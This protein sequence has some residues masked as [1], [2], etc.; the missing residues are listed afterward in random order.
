MSARPPPI[1]VFGID[2]HFK[3]YAGDAPISKG[4]NSKHRLAEKGLA[5]VRV[6]DLQGHTFSEVMVPAGD[7]LHGHVLLVA[8]AL[9]EAQTLTDGEFGRPTV[10]AFDR[11]GFSFDVLNSLAGEAFWYIAW[12][13]SSVKLPA[14]EQI[15]PSEDGVAEALW[16]HPSLTHP[17]RLLV[18]RDGDAL[19]PATSNLPPWIDATTTMELLRGARGMQE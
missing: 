17:S 5:T 15:A 2:G 1:P 9:R 4:W 8:R 6:N 18:T 10:L 12:V 11:G 14:L 16:T 13:P 3:P 19:I 7:S